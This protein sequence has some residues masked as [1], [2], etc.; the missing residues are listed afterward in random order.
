MARERG[1]GPGFAVVHSGPQVGSE[2]ADCTGPATLEIRVLSAR[3]NWA[4]VAL[5][6]FELSPNAGD[7]QFCDMLMLGLFWRSTSGTGMQTVAPYTPPLMCGVP[8]AGIR[9]RFKRFDVERL[10]ALEEQHALPFAG[11]E[12]RQRRRARRPDVWT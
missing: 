3:P 10:E 5:G 12:T 1:V 8:A 9:G 6:D 7:E 2:N 4:S 11:D